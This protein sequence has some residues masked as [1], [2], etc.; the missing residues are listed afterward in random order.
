M[1]CLI[2]NPLTLKSMRLGVAATTV[3][4]LNQKFHAENVTGLGYGIHSN[5]DCNKR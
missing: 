4:D 1:E 5:N 3:M 2:L